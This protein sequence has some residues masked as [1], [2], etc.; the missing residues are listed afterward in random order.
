L[1]VASTHLALAPLATL[2]MLGMLKTGSFLITATAFAVSS[3]L[4]S[5]CAALE[6]SVIPRKRRLTYRISIHHLT[7]IDK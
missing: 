1:F 3:L 2:T 6:T 4:A 5:L 7:T